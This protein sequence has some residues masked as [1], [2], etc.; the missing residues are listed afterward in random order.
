[1]EILKPK[2]SDFSGCI[3]IYKGSRQREI[4]IS[5]KSIFFKGE[6]IIKIDENKIVFT[7]PSITYEGKKHTLSSNK[8]GYYNTTIVSELPICTGKFEFDIE[9]SDEDCRVVYYK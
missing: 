7:K 6:L 2:E 4:K 1:M 9:E 3:T 5:S 8:Y